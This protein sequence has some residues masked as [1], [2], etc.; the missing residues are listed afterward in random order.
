LPFAFQ[1]KARVSLINYKTVF[2][3]DFKALMGFYDKMFTIASRFNGFPDWVTTGLAITLQNF[4]A[5][6]SC[7]LSDKFFV[8]ARDVKVPSSTWN[9]DEK[10][11]EMLKTVPSELKLS[12]FSRLGF[13][14]WFLFPVK[15]GFGELVYLFG[16]K[17]LQQTKEISEGIC[18]SPT[19]LGFAAHFDD[20]E[21][22]AHLRVGPMKREETEQQFGPDRMSNFAVKER[23]LPPEE[24]FAD[25]PE[26]SLLIDIDIFRSNAQATEIDQFYEKSQALRDRV[27]DNIAKYVFG[28]PVSRKK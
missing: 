11:R 14:S 27:S 28:L 2:R 4:D 8:Y 17:F 7:T 20:E 26:V 19:D 18:P 23:A 1:G 16:E 24:L 12:A 10:I 25:I 15:M 9:D 21:L 6:S 3:A 5:R 13:R 22:T